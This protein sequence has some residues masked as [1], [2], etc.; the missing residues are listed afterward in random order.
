MPGREYA[1]KRR[2][3]WWL[4]NRRYLMFQLREAGGGVCALCGLVLLNMLIQLRA[5]ESGYTA[6]LNLV[7][8]PPVLY[9]NIVLFALVGWHALP[10]FMVIG[11]APPI[12]LRR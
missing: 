7:R 12:P 1:W 6:F 10:W 8:R 5:G 11:Q 2:P 9:L 4:R 3:G